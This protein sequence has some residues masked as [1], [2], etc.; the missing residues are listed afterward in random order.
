MGLDEVLVIRSFE[1]ILKSGVKPGHE[2][3]V[4]FKQQFMFICNE[5]V[6]ED[7]AFLEDHKKCFV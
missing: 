2:K 3:V 5:L 7:I 4:D 6:N 1:F